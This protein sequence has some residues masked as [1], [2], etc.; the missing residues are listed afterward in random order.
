MTLDI[1]L[2][3][4]AMSNYAGT[5]NAITAFNVAVNN[6]QARLALQILSQVIN[7]MAEKIEAL[8]EKELNNI[9]KPAEKVKPISEPEQKKEVVIEEEVKTPQVKE[10]KLNKVKS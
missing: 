8:E 2:T 6:G 7:G 10:D 9:I 3:D 4:K 1:R 5:D